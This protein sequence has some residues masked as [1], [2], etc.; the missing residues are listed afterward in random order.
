[1]RSV[2]VTWSEGKGVQ[3]RGKITTDEGTAKMRDQYA[4]IKGLQKGKEKERLS[5]DVGI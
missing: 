4:G 3:Q 5:K 1:M 2:G